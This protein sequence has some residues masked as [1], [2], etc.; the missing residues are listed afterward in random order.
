MQVPPWWRRVAGAVP[1]LT[2][3]F[4]GPAAAAVPLQ[5]LQ[6]RGVMSVAAVP[7]TPFGVGSSKHDAGSWTHGAS[8]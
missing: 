5:R 1:E 4:T 2:V 7:S 8:A 6:G 3:G